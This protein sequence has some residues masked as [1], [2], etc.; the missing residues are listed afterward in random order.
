VMGRPLPDWESVRYELG[1]YLSLSPEHRRWIG[2]AGHCI[3]LPLLNE[4]DE[5]E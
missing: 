5:I 4:A 2:A 1:F 3:S